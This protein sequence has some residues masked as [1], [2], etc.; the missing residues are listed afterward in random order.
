KVTVTPTSPQEEEESPSQLSKSNCH[1]DPSSFRLRRISSERQITAFAL[2][3]TMVKGKLI[4]Y[5]FQNPPSAGEES[6][7]LPPNFSTKNLPAV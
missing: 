6:L 1:T 5:V 2:F 7:S 4:L 3:N